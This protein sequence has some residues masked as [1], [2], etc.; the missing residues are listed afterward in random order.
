MIK[1]TAL[2]LSKNNFARAAAKLKQVLNPTQW[3]ATDGSDRACF[4]LFTDLQQSADVTIVV[5][6][7]SDNDK[8]I[9]FN[10]SI[11]N[12]EITGINKGSEKIRY[13]GYNIEDGKLYII[14]ST[15]AGQ[16]DTSAVSPIRKMSVEIFNT[17]DNKNHCTGITALSSFPSI[18]SYTVEFAGED[19][20][21]WEFNIA[22][23]E[24]ES[25]TINSDFS[26]TV[27][28][29]KESET[30]DK[31]ANN[32]IFNISGTGVASS[33]STLDFDSNPSSVGLTV[34]V[35]TQAI[36][37]L[38]NTA[39]AEKQIPAAS[40]T[41]IGGFKVYGGSGS[42]QKST[43]QCVVKID[44][45][46]GYNYAYI[47]TNDLS[48]IVSQD[49]HRYS[50]MSLA[51]GGIVQ[52]IGQTT[53]DYVRGYFYQYTP[54][55]FN[56]SA[57]S[58]KWEFVTT[59]AATGSAIANYNVKVD[60]LISS[61]ELKFEMVPENGE[62]WI[63]SDNSIFIISQNNS[64]LV[65]L[66]YADVKSIFGIKVKDSYLSDP[67]NTLILNL[68][69]PSGAEAWKQKNVQPLLKIGSPLVFKGT[70][71]WEQL[72][73]L[74]LTAEVGDMYIV[75][76]RSNQE[77]YW[78]GTDWQFLGD[79]FDPYTE[80]NGISITSGHDISVKYDNSTIKK[81]GAGNLY[82]DGLLTDTQADWNETNT[83][84]AAY[85]NNKPTIPTVPTDVS[86]FNNDAGYLTSHQTLKTINNESL[87]GSGNVDT[88][89]EI[90]EFSTATGTLTDEQYNKL[91]GNNCAVKYENRIYQKAYTS[92]TGFDYRYTGH[93]LT[94]EDVTYYYFTVSSDTK[95]YTF[96]TNV[97]Q[98]ARVSANR[99]LSN[100]AT[101]TP[102]QNLVIGFNT[103]S[104]PSAQVNSD[105]NASSGAA[106]ILNKPSLATVATTGAYS[107]LSGTPSIPT[108]TSDL[109][110]D[111][112]FVTTN[113]K[114]KFTI[115]GVVRGDS[116][117]TDLGSLTNET[118][119][120]NGDL[121]SLV[122]TGDKYRWNANSVDS[123]MVVLYPV[124]SGTRTV[125]I[126]NGWLACNGDSILMMNSE[127]KKV[128]EISN[129]DFM[130][131][132]KYQVV[133]NQILQGTAYLDTDLN[134]LVHD[135]ISSD[136]TPSGLATTHYIVVYK[137]SDGTLQFV[138]G[139]RM[140]P[141]TSGSTHPNDA[142][143]F[144]I[145]GLSTTKTGCDIDRNDVITEQEYNAN[146]PYYL[147]YIKVYHQ[148][149]PQAL[150]KINISEY[151][152]V[153]EAYYVA[154]WTMKL[155]NMNNLSAATK[156]ALQYI[157]KV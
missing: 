22:T 147:K 6:G 97:D 157:I 83:S 56:V 17:S 71:T 90:L 43:N 126:P 25:I 109:T 93:V 143:L 110:N 8:I 72:Q 42:P 94:N 137:E 53:P 153:T 150:R 34:N 26:G 21:N 142:Y 27:E 19:Q 116:S 68:T 155:P 79:I 144:E 130:E 92:T 123:G 117:G 119:A 14:I 9:L 45:T 127:S 99:T 139:L 107:D 156:G 61:G 47:D 145:T 65:R 154:D 134:T 75:S 54:T 76:D 28:K 35:D 100:D 146:I 1:D 13:V 136:Y 85:I 113:S 67:D 70:K 131:G 86:A 82:V 148:D 58:E 81:N 15:K 57:S 12:N 74:S 38:V 64:E 101:V 20:S 114:Y 129:Y 118:A 124:G 73:N 11:Y 36:E 152:D 128:H 60:Y 4:K 84:S 30:A 41:S 149:D 111:S 52:Y 135:K 125:T 10:G 105:W 55:D 50:D 151:G 91:I 7:V 24:S 59:S 80:G 89:L 63:I 69:V 32:I 95:N 112:G 49:I 5:N 106:E 39:V 48:N 133:S 104:V 2:P 87:V 23:S 141:W 103:Y 108:K 37:N 46:D 31:L 102:L 29:I 40:T 140:L 33:S 77:Y 18:I 16:D 66:N 132:T 120:K 3:S 115:G 78:D 138:T 62:N 88:T 44:S 51:T 121:L 98:R 122:T 96:G